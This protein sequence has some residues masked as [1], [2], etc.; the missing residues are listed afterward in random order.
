MTYYAAE[1]LK[2][3]G[4]W[5]GALHS[6][7]QTM[8]G[9]GY[10]VTWSSTD[11]LVPVAKVRDVEEL[12]AIAVAADRNAHEEYARGMMIDA[13]NLLTALNNRVCLA[14][15]VELEFELRKAVDLWVNR[16]GD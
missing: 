16:K 4:A 8:F 7:V 9:N 15:Q 12:G 6:R 14:Q 13:L 2:K 1:V 3:G 11:E 10:T 5:L